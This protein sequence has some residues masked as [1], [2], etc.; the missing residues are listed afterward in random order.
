MES[1]KQNFAKKNGFEPLLIKLDNKKNLQASFG[2]KKKLPHSN[3]MNLIFSLTH[4]TFIR[5]V[6]IRHARVSMKI[7]YLASSK[8]V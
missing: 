1:P 6:C 5:C 3:I 7:G 2:K 8:V 4:G